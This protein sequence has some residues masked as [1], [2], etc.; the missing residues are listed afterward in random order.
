MGGKG[1]L[2]AGLVA[3]LGLSACD[4][5]GTIIT[6]VDA[7]AKL[8][9]TR[10][11]A[12]AAGGFPTEVHGSPFPG[13]EPDQVAGVLALP[14]SWPKDIRFRAVEPGSHGYH[15]PTRL[16]LVFNGGVPD[17]AFHC[18]LKE[19]LETAPP[20]E[21]GFNVHAVFCSGED[22]FASGYMKAP[23]VTGEDATGFRK[24]MRQL[25][26]TILD[27]IDQNRN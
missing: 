9:K 8:D 18:R 10:I 6:N 14:Q 5:G 7:T 21:V 3:A 17:P 12:N 26:R 19:P 16:V 11:T 1:G 24:A 23:R 20:S 25:L 22:W 15:N 27:Q 13:I 4:D 2:L